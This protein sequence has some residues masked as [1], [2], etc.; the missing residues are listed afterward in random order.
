MY[1]IADYKDVV[2]FKNHTGGE[3]PIEQHQ[4]N[5]LIKGI[6]EASPDDLILLSDKTKFGGINF[7]R[8]YGIIAFGC[9]IR[10]FYREKKLRLIK[11]N[12][13]NRTDFGYQ[14]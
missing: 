7:L 2:N 11:L 12:C 4:R 13:L 14:V 1:L 3:S 10:L 9:V 8:F 5:T 6:Q